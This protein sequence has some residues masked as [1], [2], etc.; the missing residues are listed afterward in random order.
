MTALAEAYSQPG[1]GRLYWCG[2]G[3]ECPKLF[4]TLLILLMGK[5]D[6]P[7][8]LLLTGLT[9]YATYFKA[10]YER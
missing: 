4:K 1:A 2:Y 9:N 7:F 5:E 6:K 3:S 10:L 8:I